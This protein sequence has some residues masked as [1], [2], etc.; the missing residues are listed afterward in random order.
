MSVR[1]YGKKEESR[2]G[3]CGAGVVSC[4]FRSDGFMGNIRRIIRCSRLEEISSLRGTRFHVSVRVLH[5]FSISSLSVFLSIRKV[6]LLYTREKYSYL[7]VPEYR[8][9]L[10]FF[11]V[12]TKSLISLIIIS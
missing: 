4:R 1:G 12:T 7:R 8:R 6:A 2:R 11:L 5:G 3:N 10:S 9:F